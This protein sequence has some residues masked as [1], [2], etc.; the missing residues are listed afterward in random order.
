MNEWSIVKL[1]Y[2]LQVKV[3]KYQKQFF[4]NYIAQKGTEMFWRISAIVSKNGSIIIEA[5]AEILVPLLGTG[6]STKIAFEISWPL[7]HNHNQ[8]KA[9]LHHTYLQARS[10]GSVSMFPI[11]NLLLTGP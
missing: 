4:W 5:M 1:K 6:V 8:P 2:E 3:G 11:V 10:P 9:I 7:V